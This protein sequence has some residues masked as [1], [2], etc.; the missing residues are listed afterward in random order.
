[1]VGSVFEFGGD[2]ERGLDGQRGEGC[3]PPFTLRMGASS[4]VSV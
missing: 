2:G 3:C 1:L 4:T